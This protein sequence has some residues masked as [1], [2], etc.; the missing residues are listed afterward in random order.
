MEVLYNTS[1]TL[2]G[3]GIDNPDIELLVKKLHENKG[4]I[5][6]GYRKLD[7]AAT[8]KIYRLMM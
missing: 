8:E 6:G 3:L 7:A 5:I 2:D 1:V 4:E